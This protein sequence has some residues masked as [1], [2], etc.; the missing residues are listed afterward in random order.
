MEHRLRVF[1]I[2]VLR[3]ISGPKRDERTGEWRK[4]RNE[5]LHYS[6][7]SPSIIRIMKARRIRFAGY[8]ARM[9]RRGMSVLRILLHNM[10]VQ[11]INAREFVAMETGNVLISEP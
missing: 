5:K 4:V 7:S 9:G 2:R 11:N 1:E 3:R 10:I 6:Y 8:V